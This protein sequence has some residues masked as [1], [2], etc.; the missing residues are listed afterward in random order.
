MRFC[1]GCG[2]E[3]SGG[4]RF[5]MHCG[6]SL[7]PTVSTPDWQAAQ[8]VE[9]TTPRHT[10]QERTTHQVRERVDTRFIGARRTPPYE[11]HVEQRWCGWWGGWGSNGG[12]ADHLNDLAQDGW[13]L[14]DSRS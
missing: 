10:L 7:V 8:D 4:A 6:H 9:P 3:L 14:T 5:C 12:F 11:Y 1:P 13:R 2:Q